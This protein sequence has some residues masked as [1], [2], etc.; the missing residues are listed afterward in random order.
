MEKPYIF[1]VILI[2]LLVAGIVSVFVFDNLKTRILRELRKSP[3]KPINTVKENEYVRLH[4]R[5][6]VIDKPLIA[7]L[8]GR[9]CVFYH[10][11]VERKGDKHWIEE[12]NETKYQD[13]YLRSGD[14][15]ARISAHDRRATLMYLV[16]DHERRS[17]WL[18]AAPEHFE[19]YLKGH[20]MS[21]KSWFFNLNKNMRYK[22]AILA[23]AE[24]VVVKG[25]AKWE[26]LEAPIFGYNYSRLL[27][28]SGNFKRKLLITDLP[29]ALK[30][31]PRKK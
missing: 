30:V 22:E 3:S 27:E 1:P 26:R 23:P 24:D 8:S 19:T 18:D 4:G 13:F 5:V 12:I 15:F 17:G 28:L 21:S 31:L 20:G 14:E 2:I 9:E 10:I 11:I 6:A 16:F 7:P 29:A 25:V